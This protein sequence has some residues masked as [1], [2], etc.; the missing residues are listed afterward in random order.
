M[1]ARIAPAPKPQAPARPAPPR[2]ELGDGSVAGELIS[3]A[4]RVIGLHGDVGGRSFLAHLLT[5]AALDVDVTAPARR[6]AA[7]V[8]HAFDADGR[9]LAPGDRVAPGDLAFF[10]HT[11]DADG[12]GRGDAFSAVAVVE[13]VGDAGLLTCIGEVHGKIR[14][15]VVTPSRPWVRRDE[16]TG[17]A[18]NTVIA[19]RRRGHSG[20]EPTLAGAL[21]GGFARPR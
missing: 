13:A 20:D 8:W 10:H 5:V 15:F 3:A 2:V 19:G 4:R 7:A 11:T 21:L 14:R 6:Y 17:A 12:D 9:V 1:L 18:V 16:R